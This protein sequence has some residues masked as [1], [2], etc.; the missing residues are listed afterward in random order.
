MGKQGKVNILAAVM[1]KEAFDK[2]VVCVHVKI[3]KYKVMLTPA[4]FINIYI[5]KDKK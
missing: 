3:G 2:E 1:L 4:E 5:P